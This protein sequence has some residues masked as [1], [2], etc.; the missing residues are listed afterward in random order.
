LGAEPGR[1]PAVKRVRRAVAPG[2]GE[3]KGE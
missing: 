2:A 3:T 1:T